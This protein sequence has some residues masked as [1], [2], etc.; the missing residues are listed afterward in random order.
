[1]RGN[2]KSNRNVNANANAPKMS[3]KEKAAAEELV[4]QAELENQ[5]QEIKD[6]RFANFWEICNDSSNANSLEK[7]L[8]AIENGK[9]IE[10]ES[11]KNH[12][13]NVVLLSDKDFLNFW[14][15]AMAKKLA[16]EQATVKQALY[17]NFWESM[18][19]NEYINNVRMINTNQFDILSPLFKDEELL[20]FFK[21]KK[22]QEGEQ[23]DRE[24]KTFFE[25][26]PKM[27]ELIKLFKNHFFLTNY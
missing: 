15:N 20:K 3:K 22:Q 10:D 8:N 21:M 16:D 18:T 25:L 23:S 7:L 12:I 27:S 19:E 4:K 2:Q 9:T 6:A 5:T 17:L 26:L 11:V 24:S 14:Q 1:M 13:N